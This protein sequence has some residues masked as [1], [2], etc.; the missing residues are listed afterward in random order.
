MGEEGA[1][2]LGGVFARQ[3]AKIDIVEGVDGGG[4]EVVGLEA[5]SVGKG[6]L[7]VLLRKL[8]TVSKERVAG[9]VAEVKKIA[10]EGGIFVAQ[11]DEIVEIID[12][13]GLGGG[14]FTTVDKAIEFDIGGASVTVAGEEIEAIK[15]VGKLGVLLGERGVEFGEHFFFV[16]VGGE[17]GIAE[18]F[19][20]LVAGGG[21]TG[22]RSLAER[23]EDKDI[24]NRG[25]DEN[26]DEGDKEEEGGF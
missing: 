17:G 21:G 25:T 6:G 19:G 14:E 4:E 8:G 16:N 10:S 9:F 2:D 5:A 12:R 23:L 26:E 7:V 22:V 20:E 13:A 1:I 3:T 24:S 18:L 15:F 11:G